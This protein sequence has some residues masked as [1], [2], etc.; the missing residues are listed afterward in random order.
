MM[1]CDCCDDKARLSEH[2][3][4]SELA[5]LPSSLR[6]SV[7]YSESYTEARQQTVNVSFSRTFLTRNGISSTRSWK[8]GISE[9][10][11]I[12]Q[13]VGG[14]DSE[15]E[16]ISESYGINYNQSER[17]Q[18]GYQ[19]EDGE[20]WSSNAREGESNSTYR[21]YMAGVYGSTSVEGTVG[22][23]G[24]F[25]VPGMGQVT[26]S[27]R[28][29]AGVKVGGRYNDRTGDRV[30]TSSE[31]GWGM[32]GDRSESTRF[33]SSTTDNR[34]ES[35]SGTYAL[36]TDRNRSYSDTNSREQTRTWSFSEGLRQTDVVSQGSEE[37]ESQTWVESS[38]DTTTQ[39]Y[40]GFIPNGKGGMFYR[41]TTRWVRTASVRGY[42]LCGVATDLGE[43]QFNE[44]TWAPDLALN[45]SCA[46][47]NPKTNMPPA[48]CFIQPCDGL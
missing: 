15:S 44:W 39:G 43:M 13:T 48:A 17:N 28:T 8:E 20:S 37:R 10:E 26:G 38:S 22:V 1:G 31:S 29:S 45:E 33:G 7:K 46:D 14:T 9:G 21:D 11:R 4:A 32:S 25:G 2:F 19:S 47:G 42:D 40:S 16:R 35:M 12:S 36:S 27:T 18:V 34:S 41:Q 30:G 23:K 6:S 3:A 24:E 5:T